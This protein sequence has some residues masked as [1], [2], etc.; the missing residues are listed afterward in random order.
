MIQ[1]IGEIIWII[2][3]TF[4]LIGYMYLE[5]LGVKKLAKHAS[6]DKSLVS[7]LQ[8]TRAHEAHE[9]HQAPS[10]AVL[11][12]PAGYQYCTIWFER[13]GWLKDSW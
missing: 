12:Q 4:L 6:D 5:D 7:K 3:I 10:A 9:A 2:W 8:T 13:S 11:M 1:L